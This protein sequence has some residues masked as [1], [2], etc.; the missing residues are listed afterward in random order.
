MY[1]TLW[2]IYVRAFLW[3]E[4]TDNL[5]NIFTK[6]F[7]ADV[8]QW[9]K[10]AF[11][12]PCF[13]VNFSFKLYRDQFIKDIQSYST[14]KSLFITRFIFYISSFLRLLKQFFFWNVGLFSRKYGKCITD[15]STLSLLLLSVRY[16]L[17]LSSVL[18]AT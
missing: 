1:R 5:S 10:Y 8:W 2:N 16:Q 11:S 18:Y 15:G 12:C 13:S 9:S 6:K 17:I 7:H 3:K 4:L 14:Q